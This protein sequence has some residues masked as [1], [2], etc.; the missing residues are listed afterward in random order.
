MSGSSTSEDGGRLQAPAWL[1]ALAALAAASLASMAL[2]LAFQAQGERATVANLLDDAALLFALAAATHASLHTLSTTRTMWRLLAVGLLSWVIGEAIFDVRTQILDRSMDESI[3]D[4]F[5]VLFYP[6]ALAALWVR[7]REARS[8]RLDVRMLDALIVAG[9]AALVA[10]DLVYDQNF[11]SAPTSAGDIARAAYPV[12][13]GLLL[14]VIAYQAYNPAIVWDP[15]RWLLAAGTVGLL[16]ADIFW[17]V[18]G[19]LEYA[20]AVSAAML[21]IGAAAILTPETTS[22]RDPTRRLPSQLVPA[23]VLSAA[24]AAIAATLV[25]NVYSDAPVLIVGAMVVMGIVL[26]RLLATLAL[27]DRLLV[28]SEERAVSDSLTGLRN[29]QYFVERLDVEVQRADRDGTPVALL[30][31]DIDDFKLINDLAGHRAGDRALVSIAEAMNASSRATDIVCRLGGD[32]LA[33][34]APATSASEAMGLAERLRARVHA[35]VISEL[36]DQGGVSV[37]IGCCVYPDIS[38]SSTELIERADETLYAV[39]QSG[40]DRA[41]IYDHAA[42]HPHDDAWQLA[43]TKAELAARNADF[44][45]VF[46]HAHEAMVITDEDGT[47]LMANAASVRMFGAAREQM[48]G[49]SVMEFVRPEHKSEL[50]DLI[51]NTQTAGEAEGKLHLVVPGDEHLLVAFSTSRFAPGRYLTIVR[52]I[53]E[54][55]EAAERLA[56]SE[57]HF[58]AVFENSIDPMFV[59]DDAGIVRDANRAAALLVE[60]SL[61]ELIGQPVEQLMEAGSNIDVTALRADL[62][63]VQEQ[64]GSLTTRDKSGKVRTFEYTAVADFVPGRHLSIVRDVSDRASLPEKPES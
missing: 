10:Y 57:A 7:D 43:R 1:L 50:A 63:S 9:A 28:E 42:T 64:Q 51:A 25:V 5:Y 13:D 8:G 48:I 29:R 56:R 38:D 4:V 19:A 45:A 14:W 23:I 59:T 24:I 26:V 47:V 6:F 22:P 20:I 49:R 61:P 3:A 31:I 30:M 12:F 33:I 15:T 27:N 18:L 37:S 60:R 53:S 17:N 21:C 34:I 41:A 54:S 16:V 2:I 35:I 46:A 44:R 62:R 40:R 55:E 11:D 58:R 36:A 39:K 52:D 32:E